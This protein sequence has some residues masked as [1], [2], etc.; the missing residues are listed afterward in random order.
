VPSNDGHGDMMYSPYGSRVCFYCARDW[1]RIQEWNFK[2]PLSF[3]GVGDVH[4]GIELEVET[5]GEGRDYARRVNPNNQGFTYMMRDGSLD[6]GVEFA[7]MP[8][9]FDYLVDKK[10]KWERIM[11]LIQ[12]GYRANGN[13][14]MHVHIS[15]KAFQSFHLWKFQ[16]FFYAFQ[17]FIVSVSGR[18]SMRA[19][20]RWSPLNDSKEDIVYKAKNK[21]NARSNRYTAVNM[22]NKHTIEVRIFASTMDD[23]IFWKNVQFIDALV[24]WT[25]DVAPSDLTLR[26]FYNY[27]KKNQ[28][29]YGALYEWARVR[30]STLVRGRPSRNRRRN[31]RG[32]FIDMDLSACFNED[33]D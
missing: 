23:K 15:R 10:E 3:Y 12:E 27:I 1:S 17:R 19:L 2:P 26:H 33:D 22:A 13:C 8:A 6:D 25:R 7:S 31:E 9:S 21:G 4:Y 30:Y 18:G 11:D 29:T 28:T 32:A 14:G 20:E 16:T 5:Q 24:N